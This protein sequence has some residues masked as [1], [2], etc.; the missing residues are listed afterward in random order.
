[1]VICNGSTNYAPHFLS[2]CKNQVSINTTATKIVI[3]VGLVLTIIMVKIISLAIEYFRIWKLNQPSIV[4]NEIQ[5]ETCFE[6]FKKRLQFF[7]KMSLNPLLKRLMIIV[8]NKQ[9]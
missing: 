6:D 8:M 5:I 7:L 4:L 1:M 2:L 3:A 9:K